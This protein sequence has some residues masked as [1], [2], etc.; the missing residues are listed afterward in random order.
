MSYKP[1]RCTKCLTLGEPSTEPLFVSDCKEKPHAFCSACLA[2]LPE[3]FECPHPF[4]GQEI[5]KKTLRKSNLTAEESLRLQIKE[6]SAHRC[7]K[8][9]ASKNEVCPFLEC[10][11]RFVPC[12]KLCLP[13]EHPKCDLSQ[14]IPFILFAERLMPFGCD[15]D[16]VFEKF[17]KAMALRITLDKSEALKEFIKYESEVLLSVPLNTLLS[18]HESYLIDQAGDRY[19]FSL[20]SLLKIDKL[21]MEAATLLEQNRDILEADPGTA[22]HRLSSIFEDWNAAKT[23][24]KIK[25]SIVSERSRKKLS[26]LGEADPEPATPVLS[27]TMKKD[28]EQEIYETGNRSPSRPRSPQEEMQND[29][30][31]GDIV[32]KSEINSPSLKSAQKTQKVAEKEKLREKQAKPQKNIP[33]VKEISKKDSFAV[34]KEAQKSNIELENFRKEVRMMVDGERKHT[35]RLIQEKVKASVEPL[36]DKIARLEAELRK[37]QSIDNLPDNSNKKVALRKSDVHDLDDKVAPQVEK[38]AK[39]SVP[40]SMK[41]INNKTGDKSAHLECKKQFSVLKAELDQLARTVEETSKKSSLEARA[42]RQA[43]EAAEENIKGANSKF[44][45]VNA[46]IKDSKDSIFK[47]NQR[48]DAFAVE[49]IKTEKP[50]KKPKLDTNLNTEEPK[51]RHTTAAEGERDGKASANLKKI[52]E[53]DYSG[54]QSQKLVTVK[55][56]PQPSLNMPVFAGSYFLQAE[57]KATLAELVGDLEA[58]VLIFNTFVHGT[59][60]TTFHARCDNRGPTLV[61]GRLGKYIAG[62]YTDQS[63]GDSGPKQ[64]SRSFM[65]SVTK[66]RKYELRESH[67][68]ITADPSLGPVFGSEI[69]RN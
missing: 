55:E 66:N 15:S 13:E 5:E 23:T 2:D 21:M 36:L 45:R 57:H 60:A 11:H 27:S 4:C 16:K 61:V 48:I 64:S 54:V 38:S 51:P 41:E 35:E 44:E 50:E 43:I 20:K 69:T 59:V 68:A 14:V 28:R 26:M 56:A 39:V 10:A 17:M 46:Q 67:P 65:F 9:N 53:T 24:F 40:Q 63:W 33:S 3:N 30:S 37:R 31:S 52:L 6:F 19:V 18:G 7:N 49:R 47:L 62:G 22:I 1:R 34:K 58:T 32:I 12:C 25:F 42:L 8:H 29:D